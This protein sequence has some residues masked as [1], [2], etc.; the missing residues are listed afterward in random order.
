MPS[1]DTIFNRLQLATETEL[2]E[3]CKALKID[4]TKNLNQISKEYRSASGHFMANLFRDSDEL[5][6]KR[7][8]I[9]V[10]DKLKP[11]FGWTD[12]GMDDYNT[13]E[14]IEETILEYVNNKVEEEFKKLSKEEREKA[15][16]QFR[17]KL[18]SLGY[19]QAIIS[20]L[21]SAVA[22]GALATALATPV[23]ISIFYSGVMASLWASIFGP[24]A[25]LLALSGT[26]VALAVA[27][28][29][30]AVTLGGPAYS[31]T[32]PATIQFITVR[33][34]IEAEKMLF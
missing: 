2:G 26:G 3:I 11:G 21:S 7:I 29:L 12:F 23:T 5:P 4:Y 30:L 6:Y 14:K 18:E 15:A 22:S 1:N 17:D 31:K 19:D 27:I 33:K 24:S 28:P 8:L 13:E 25:F 10:A 32:I 34:R 9:D 20:S 16:K